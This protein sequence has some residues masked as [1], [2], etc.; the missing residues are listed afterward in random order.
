MGIDE[1]LSHEPTVETRNRRPMRPNPLAPWELRIG[2]LHIYY[3]VGEDPDPVVYI[4]AVG[5]K[6][7]ESLRIGKAVIR[8]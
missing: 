2:A 6:H 7:R 5:M 1:Q 3:D 4:L 8:L